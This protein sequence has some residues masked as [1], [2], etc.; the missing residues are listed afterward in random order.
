MMDIEEIYKKYYK[1]KKECDI[2]DE[3][4]RSIDDEEYALI[5]QYE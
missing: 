1:A 2:Y 5:K 4:D 3:I